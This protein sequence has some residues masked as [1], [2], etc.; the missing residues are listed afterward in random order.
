MLPNSYD[1]LNQA[2]KDRVAQLLDFIGFPGGHALEIGARRGIIT[3]LLLDR[4]DRITA[5]DLE[6]PAFSLP[7]VTTMAGDITDLEFAND[8]FDCVIC[9]EVLEH[10]PGN[11]L[12]R[13]CDELSRVTR[14]RLVIGLP[15]KQDIRL[16]RTVCSGCGSSNPPYGHV[17]SFDEKKLASLFPAMEAQRIDY[18]GP[19][20]PATNAL[21]ALL[22]D[23]AGN[24]WGTYDQAEPCGVCGHPLN[25][26]A[27]HK[28]HQPVLAAT[29]A[30]LTR[31]QNRI[32][33]P[34]PSW[35]HVSFHK[36]AN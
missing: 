18:V 32:R 29:S 30:R 10:I 2:D 14:K 11:L 35:F 3:K 21:S 25:T 7:S 24:P 19:P 22:M 27:S 1:E 9:S 26:P 12:Q 31:L 6:Q 20:S 13:A 16:G 34:N 15:Y 23:W 17:N 28:P 4:F 36:R 33:K 5:L 8:V